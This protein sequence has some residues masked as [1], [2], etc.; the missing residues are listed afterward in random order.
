MTQNDGAIESGRLRSARGH[1]GAVPERLTYSV[2]EAAQVL[3]I[4]VEA[5]WKRVWDHTIPSFRVGRRVL[6]SR[7]AIARIIDGETAADVSG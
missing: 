4:S 2:G 6:I 5:T 1:D 3:G 7:R